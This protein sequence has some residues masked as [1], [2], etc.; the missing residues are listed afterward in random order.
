MDIRDEIRNLAA[1]W[2]NRAYATKF[3][4]RSVLRDLMIYA[5]LNGVS[6]SSDEGMLLVE[7]NRRLQ[8]G[9]LEGDYFVKK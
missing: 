8:T 5:F 7:A 3:D 1:K 6:R 4:A 2:L 9:S